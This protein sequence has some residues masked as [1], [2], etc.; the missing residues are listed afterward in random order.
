MFFFKAGFAAIISEAVMGFSLF[1]KTSRTS[2]S[3]LVNF[4]DR[5]NEYPYGESGLR[6]PVM[7]PYFMM[8]VLI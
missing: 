6:I 3:R 8:G 7:I 2:R 4:A 5:L 1:H